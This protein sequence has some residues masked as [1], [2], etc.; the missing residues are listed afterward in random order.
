MPL[1]D[2]AFPFACRRH[3]QSKHCQVKPFKCDVCDVAFSQHSDM[4]S[5]KNQVHEGRR[6][7]ACPHC[8]SKF[9]R[10]KHLLDHLA[11]NHNSY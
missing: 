6:P 4:V 2:D 7:H 11:S 9:K 3:I 8:K 1:V 10:K 5:H